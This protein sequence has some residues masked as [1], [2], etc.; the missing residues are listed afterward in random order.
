MVKLRGNK[1]FKEVNMKKILIGLLVLILAGF[2]WKQ[3]LPQLDNPAEATIERKSTLEIP[4]DVYSVDNVSGFESSWRTG[5]ELSSQLEAVYNSFSVTLWAEG[6]KVEIY[7]DGIQWQQNQEYTIHGEVEAEVSTQIVISVRNQEEVLEE[8]VIDG[9]M[10]EFSFSFI[11]PTNNDWT[12][13]VEFSFLQQTTENRVTVSNFRL[14]ENAPTSAQARVNQVGYLPTEAKRV[15]FP[16]TQGDFFDVVDA[17]TNEVVYTGAIVGAVWDELAG[18]RTSYGDF[19]TF[20]TEGTYYIRSQLGG[21]SYPFQ[22]SDSLYEEVSADALRMIF[23]QRCGMDLDESLAGDLAHEACHLNEAVLYSDSGNGFDATGGWHDAGDYGRYVETGSKAVLDLLFSYQRFPDS[24]GDDLNIAES[25]N[26]VPDVLDEVRY[27]LEWFLKLQTTEGGVYNKITTPAFAE[28]LLPEE[29]NQQLYALPVETTTT[30]DF[31]AVMALASQIYE[32]FD[33]EFAAT[34]L[35]A[36]KLSWENLR[37]TG[38]VLD[39]KNPS[40]FSTGSYRDNKDSDER[41]LASIALWIATGETPYLDYAKQVYNEDNSA[42]TGTSW[43][44]VGAYGAYLYLIQ[45]DIDRTSEFYKSLHE[46]LSSQANAITA[47]IE[48]NNYQVGLEHFSWGSNG[49]ILNQSIILLMMSDVDQNPYYRRLASEQ[50]NYIFGKNALNFSFVIGY[51]EDYPDNPHHRIALIQDAEILGAVVGGVSGDR[52]DE[53]LSKLP[54]STPIAKMYVDLYD[55][56][57]SNEVTVYWNSSLV[58]VLSYFK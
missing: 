56:Y 29:D 1:I 5:E 51:G 20:I 16:Y 44:D 36:A 47:I 9:Q 10:G 46:K 11:S 7:Q 30:G 26:G 6:P 33:S 18:E 35:N 39:Y 21:V 53:V 55:S 2:V 37:W 58:Y 50:L 13:S 8:W 14:I 34:C 54:D 15:T 17:N 40:E 19:S 28:N 12:G 38:E 23:Y 57:G 32:D 4:T 42:A 3:M 22:I 45:E 43:S 52:D 48:R 31:I 24:Y 41:F 49:K 27:E 25:S